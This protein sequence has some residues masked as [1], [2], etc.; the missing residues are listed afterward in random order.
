TLTP[1]HPDIKTKRTM[2]F[3]IES[4]YG[5]FYTGGNIE[6]SK[7]KLF[8]QTS[9]T[10]NCLDINTGQV[11]SKINTENED[12]ENADSIQTFTRNNN[13]IITSHK[14][15]LLKLW[16]LDGQLIKQWKYIHKGP[17]AKLTLQNQYLASGGSDSAVRLWDLEYQTCLLCLKGASGVVN[18]VEFHPTEDWIFGSGDDGK[19]NM[20]GTTKGKLCKVFT[21]HYSKVTSLC[22]H[23][24]YKHFITAGRDKVLILWKIDSDSALKTIPVYEVVE[25]VVSLPKKFKLPHNISVNQSDESIYIAT[26]GSKGVIRIWDIVNCKEIYVQQQNSSINEFS[27]VNLLFDAELKTFMVVS[28]EHTIIMYDLKMFTCRKQFVGFSNLLFDAELKTF[29]V[30]SQEHT[31]IMYDL[32]TFSCRKQFVGFS[33]EILDAIYVGKDDSHLAIATNSADIKLYK[34]STMSCTFLKG[35]T[36]LVL[37]LNKCI[38]KP[39]LM[40]S[41][42]KDN[43][44]RLWQ[45]SDDTMHCVGV[46]LR[47]TGSVGSVAFGNSNFLVS[48]SQDTCVKVWEVPS[49]LDADTN[50]Y[51]SHTQVAHEKDINSVTVS[52]NNKM[53]A[54]GSQDKTVKLWS[55]NLEFFGALRGHKRGVWCVKFSPIDQVLL[56]SSADTTIKLWSII[57]LNCLKTFESHEGSVLRI[58]FITSGMQFLSTDG[59]GLIKLFNVKTSEC[60]STLSQHDGRIWALAVKQNEDQFT[61]GGSDSLLIKWRDVTQEKIMQQSKEREEYILQEQQL[62]NYLQNDQFL[63][64]LKIALRL[65]KPLHVLKIVQNII[66]KGESGLSDTI[67][68]LGVDQKEQLL[69]VAISWNTNSKYCQPAQVVLNVLLNEF[70]SGKLL[71]TGLRNTLEGALPYTERH[72]KRL[73]QLLQD[74]YFIS[75]VINCMQPHARIK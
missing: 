62:Y 61:T 70:Q 23:S 7:E 32:K 13:N 42:S 60:I 50:L 43:S 56:S 57:D 54:T 24:D 20:W 2:N 68:E 19:I 47:H 5:A 17:I 53:I 67:G 59:N 35:H 10:I 8:C 25:T 3:D 21:G 6:W 41:S 22:F 69:K 28:Q 48:V 73:T 46:G 11:V 18:V 9:S 36:D 49:K 14:S 66:S 26:A 45:M 39:T 63:K 4:K 52:P 31:I 40:A 37:A 55:E 44:I 71:S 74:L 64:A 65:D 38:S 72:F 27:I 58:E 16:D 34:D 15:G 75:Y 29:M 33:D 1:I 30:V 51:C 12:G